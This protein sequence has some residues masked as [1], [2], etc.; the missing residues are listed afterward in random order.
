M[1]I[2]RAAKRK[3]VLK[4]LFLMLGPLGLALAWGTAAIPAGIEYFYSLRFSK[5]LASFL[6]LTSGIFPFSLAEVLVVLLVLLLLIGIISVTVKSLISLLKIWHP[7]SR[8]SLGKERPRFRQKTVGF[9]AYTYRAIV[10]LGVIYF[11][12]ILIWGLNYN[13]LSFAEIAGLEVQESSVEEL[14]ELSG[15]LIARANELRLSLPEDS[16][17]VFQLEGGFEAVRTLAP[18]ALAK[19][20]EIYPELKGNFGRP[21]P[22]FLSELMSY[23]GITGIYF[24]FTGEANVNVDI[25]DS[26][27]PAT[28]C[29]E[30]AHQRGFAR[31]DEANY[32]AW[33]ACNLS[34]EPAFQYSGVQMALIYAMNALYEHAPEKALE[35]Q[36]QYS[37]QVARDLK[38]IS[39]YWKKYEGKAEEVVSD[40]ND[41]YLKSN[42]QAE[43]VQSYGRMVDLLLA[44]QKADREKRMLP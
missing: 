18:L 26:Q 29:H 11:S 21:K 6:S 35:L 19:A 7:R 28:T 27:L 34:E 14:A 12:F 5:S 30:L 31:E 25:P 36:Q 44:E 20:G 15:R 9:L 33:V 10:L 39:E 2:K 43:G 16:R 42:R 23:T 3:W 37:P 17:G 22:V 40:I 41:A 13:R 1:K 4:L 38:H 8:K 32:I 24:P